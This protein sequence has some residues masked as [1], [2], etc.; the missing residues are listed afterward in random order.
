MHATTHLNPQQLA[1]VQHVEGPLLVIAGAGSGKTRVVTHRITH[2]LELGVP[3]SEILA[4]TFTNKAAE[5]MRQ[6]VLNLASYNVLTCTFHSLGARILRE[7]IHL[8]GYASHFTIFDEEDSE[9]V[10]K[11]CF[12]LLNVKEDKAFFKTIR[13]QI[14]Q[15]KNLLQDPAQLSND[16]SF[17]S[18]VYE[19]Y[20]TKLKEYNAVDFDDLL[21]LTVKLFQESE[22]TLKNYQRRWSFILIDEYQDTNHA[23]SKMI[24]LLAKQHHNVFAVGDPDQSIYSWRGADVQNILSFEKDYPGAKIISLE[25]NYRSRNN[26]LR[27]ANEL[28]GHNPRQYEKNLWSERGEGEKIGLFISESEQLETEFVVKKLLEH[29][30][31]DLI[32]FSECVIFYRTNFQSR[33]FEDA[34][35]RHRIPYV[36]IGGLSFYQRKEIKDILAF[37]RLILGSPDFLSFSRA[38]NLPKR[39]FGEATLEKLRAF[40]QENSQDVFSTS[41]AIVQ[42]QKTFKLSQRQFEGLKKFVEVIFS[43]REELK[44]QIPLNALLTKTIESIDYFE[45]LKEDPETYQ[46][47]RENIEELISKA[48]E[49]EEETGQAS[50]TSFLEELSLK[51]SHEEKDA[52]KDSVRLMTLH[53]GKGLE[54]SV[55]F[56]VGMEEDLFPHINS[57]NSPLALE[58]ERRLCYVGMTR[59]KDYLYLSASRYRFLWG[60]ARFMHPSRFLQEIPS[61]YFQPHHI[62]YARRATQEINFEPDEMIFQPGETVAHRDFGVG[63]VQKTYQTALGLTYDVLFTQTNKTRS[64]VAKYAKLLPH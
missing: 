32:P 61:E 8:L 62:T 41:L 26:I 22:E 16:D 13:A 11:E 18:R 58:E 14:S 40:S 23:Q 24:K 33:V 35:L 51:S 19:L 64:L 21:F 25:Q 49:W 29:H 36:V 48:A 4:V 15:A 57:K 47:R 34:L 54:F 3:A 28:I 2:L 59:A 53:N 46:E 63:I 17:L 7:S 55:V 50:L 10:L 39:G 45:L 60:G 31:N 12:T 43:L 9:K 44:K 30:D 1:V 38:I 20:Q 56:L 52:T 42:G 37:L 27:A 6:R 5:E